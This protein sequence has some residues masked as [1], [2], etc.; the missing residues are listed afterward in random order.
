MDLSIQTAFMWDAPDNGTTITG[1]DAPGV[2]GTLLLGHTTDDTGIRAPQHV[3][4]MTVQL[5]DESGSPSPANDVERYQAM[6]SG[7]RPAGNATQPADYRHLIAAGPFAQLDPGESLSLR[8]AYVIGDGQSGFRASAVSAQRVFDGRYMDADQNPNTGIN[9]KERCLQ[10]LEPGQQIVWDDPCDTLATTVVFDHTDPCN[11]A[12]PHYVDADCD[13]CTGVNGEETNISWVGV[14]APPSPNTNL[15]SIPP[16]PGYE[17]V[18][19]PAGNGRVILQWDNFS[20]LWKDPITGEALFEGYR[21][22]KVDN[23][24]G[25]PTGP[26]PDDFMLIG[27]FRL[28][29]EM[30]GRP[31]GEVLNRGVEAIGQTDDGK[32]IYPV[33]RYEFIDDYVL[34]DHTYFYSIAAFGITS[35]FNPVTGQEEIVEI[36]GFPSASADQAVVPCDTCEVVP[37]RLLSFSAERVGADAVLRWVVS[38]AID[39]AGFHVHRRDPGKERIRLTETLLAD[40]PEYEFRDTEAPPGPAEYWLEEVSRAG[41]RDWH[42]PARLAPSATLPTRFLVG[43]A[44]PNPFQSRMSISYALPESR[45][46]RVSVYDLQGRRVRMLADQV[47]GPGEFSLEWRGDADSGVEVGTGLYLI[48]VEAGPEALTRKVLFVR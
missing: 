41:A 14:V 3:G 45:P 13:P 29:P 27:I 38:D 11:G 47:Q 2:F 37:V 15:G 34:N 9:G 18:I 25:G 44:A 35:V 17:H 16:G 19:P 30:G 10:I 4:L 23:W 33:G 8:I 48:R 5:F 31:L 21:I 26:A 1:G 43:M 12:G 46:V 42:G 40:G 6:A 36:A 32:S 7:T 39:H 20:E 24:T 28:Q 22:Y